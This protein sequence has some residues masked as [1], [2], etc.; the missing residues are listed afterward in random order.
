MSYLYDNVLEP[1]SS[2]NDRTRIGPMPEDL[3]A[4]IGRIFLYKTDG[5]SEDP[6]KS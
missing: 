5:L 2:P 3:F 4:I 6:S 1:P